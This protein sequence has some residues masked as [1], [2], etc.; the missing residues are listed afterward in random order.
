MSEHTPPPWKWERQQDYPTTDLKPD[1]LSIYQSHGGGELPKEADA[2]LIEASPVL[3]EFVVKR[4]NDGD[5]EAMSIL[6]TIRSAFG[7]PEWGDW[8]D[9]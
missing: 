4:A 5:V 2:R 6:N 1:V 8:R 7:K 3:F 9:E